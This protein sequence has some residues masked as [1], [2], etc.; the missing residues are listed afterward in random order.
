MVSLLKSVIIKDKK[1]IKCKMI[2]NIKIINIKKYI[3][4]KYLVTKSIR[5][6]I[7][8]YNYLHIL[9]LILFK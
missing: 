8:L 1:M 5:D 3:L 9:K 2:K 4:F 7:F 6:L